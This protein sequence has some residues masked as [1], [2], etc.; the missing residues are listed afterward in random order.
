MKIFNFKKT[1]GIILATTVLCCAFAGTAFTA[2]ATGGKIS[3]VFSGD[4][5]EKSGYAEG[6]VTLQGVADGEYSL[7]WADNSKALEGYYEISKLKIKGGKGSFSFGDHTAIPV[8]AKKIIATTG[9]SK[10]VSDAVAVYD[11]PDY[12]KPAYK[13][14]D[15]NYTF[16][17]YSDIHIDK[18]HNLYYTYSEMHFE[19]ALEVAANRN[20]DFIVTAGD[21]ITNAEGPA[22]E[23]DTYQQILADSPYCNPI[24]E[25]SGNHEIR[26]GEPNALL[27][28]FVDATGLNG[29]K[30]D[31]KANKPYY[32]LTEPNSNDLFIFMSLEFEYNPQDGNEFSKKQLKWLKNILKE[33]Y[34]KNKNIFLIEHA[35]I[36][37][38]GAG[39]DPDNF[40]TVPLNPEYKTTNEFR[41]IIE[42]YPDIIWIS[43]HTHIA[44][45]Y[46]YNYSNMND[47]SCHM[48][49]DSSVCCPT[50]LNYN[51]HSLSY[52]AHDSEEYKDLTEGY[53]VQVFDDCIIFNGE[54]L[55]YDKIYPASCYI[56]ESCRD[57]LTES[58][59]SMG[60]G[61]AEPEPKD[62]L[63]LAE[64]YM[65]TPKSI[66]LEDITAE[67]F[68]DLLEKSQK[69][70]SD[71]YTFSSYNQYQSLKK[72]VKASASTP[73][74]IEKAYKKLSD[75]YFE[76]LPFT[77]KGEIT[78][79]Y[80]NTK[81]WD[82]VFAK[83]WSAKNSNG[84]IGEEMEYVTTDDE[85]TKIYKITVNTNTYKQV[86]FNDGTK[87]HVTEN[88]TISIEN[89][90][91]YYANA[92]DNYS[93]YFCLVEDYN[94]N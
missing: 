24:Y 46:G 94:S 35:L 14:E 15:A 26:V 10:K 84:D 19:K 6:K 31:I 93:P 72:I 18:Q 67:D 57:E 23:F 8:D 53:Y 65:N 2:N 60:N 48:I 29:Y 3:Y 7:Y 90:K 61:F 49:H 80:G 74:D 22:N 70:L 91:K 9:D 88:Q 89:N 76:M 12:K 4:E 81:G 1:V 41:D 83:F 92:A 66:T 59:T 40:Y 32:C 78:L 86:A 58:S 11:I 64:R 45:E 51:S 71:F 63:A 56:V 44:L 21:N 50:L 68:E 16:M 75:A 85:G 73:K 38:Y 36:E 17:N 39:D 82:K 27:T 52:I 69:L 20:V 54:N 47:T 55:Y 43:G 62:F 37:S 33:N 42:S 79:Y 87:K 28:T 30:Q 5:K 34:G 25:A 13:S 77:L